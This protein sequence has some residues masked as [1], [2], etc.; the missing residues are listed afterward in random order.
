MLI[1]A[2]EPL[3]GVTSDFGTNGSSTN[4]SSANAN[5]STAQH[6]TRSARGGTMVT[7]AAQVRPTI[8][9]IA[10]R[11]A[12]SG[13][14][15]P[16]ALMPTTDRIDAAPTQSQAGVASRSPRRIEASVPR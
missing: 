7:I 1:Q 5:A 6:R 15:V 10:C 11:V 13:R 14:V 4:T 8:R 3:R 12:S 16:M 2:R 9:N